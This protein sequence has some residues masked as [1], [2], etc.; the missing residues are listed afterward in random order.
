M[1][2]FVGTWP[3]APAWD[4][5]IDDFIFFCSEHPDAEYGEFSNWHNTHYLDGP[6]QGMCG[7][8]FWCSE[9]EL[10][11]QKLNFCKNTKLAE[12]QAAKILTI[13]PMPVIPIGEEGW[14]D[15]WK[16]NH[17]L[18]C[19]IKQYCRLRELELEVDKWD[20]AKGHIMYEIIVNKFKQPSYAAI[21]AKTNGHVIVEAAHYD[22]AFGIGLQ[23]GSFAPRNK[24]GME[25]K[26][27]LKKLE[28]GT[29]VW[30]I[31]PGPQWGQNIL[32]EALMKVREQL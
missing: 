3:V 8:R 21:L 12:E 29:V 16:V 25:D 23:V 26:S 6:Y 5:A 9:Q 32:G 14:E 30:N 15:V 20:L 1:T 19:Q 10:M 28:N 27:V 31:P 2:T 7:H 13:Q 18:A 22:P 4:A 24:H 11:L 17:D